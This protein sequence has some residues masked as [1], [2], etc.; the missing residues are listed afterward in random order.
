LAGTKITKL[1]NSIQN[2]SKLKMLALGESTELL[3]E[4]IGNL[5]NLEELNMRNCKQ[6]KKL[7]E[8]FFKLR[9]LRRFYFFGSGITTPPF[10][11]QRYILTL[12]HRFPLLADIRDRWESPDIKIEIDEACKCALGRNRFRPKNPFIIAKDQQCNEVVSKLWP[13]LL[14]KASD[15]FGTYGDYF[16]EHHDHTGKFKKVDDYMKDEDSKYWLLKDSMAS[17]VEVLLHRKL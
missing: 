13:R 7:P 15:A 9:G 16:E 12:T 8:S 14:A 10:D 4:W 2:L 5:S 11:Q 17:F 6:I 3:P 1:P